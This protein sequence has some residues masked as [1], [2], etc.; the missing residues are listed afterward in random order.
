MKK[1]MWIT[2]VTI[3]CVKNTTFICK[4]NRKY[5]IIHIIERRYPQ[6]V[7]KKDKNQI[8]KYL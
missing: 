1:G 4:K 5:S 8:K 2:F 3:K 6:Y 7:D